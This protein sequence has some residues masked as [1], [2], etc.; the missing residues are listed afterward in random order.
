MRAEGFGRGH[1]QPREQRHQERVGA[2]GT[3]RAVV[4]AG[5]V[6]EGPRRHPEGSPVEVAAER[7]GEDA[8]EPE[9][10]RRPEPAPELDGGGLVPHRHEVPTVGAR[11][12]EV[13]HH[14]LLRCVVGHLRGQR[15]EERFG[16]SRL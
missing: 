6:A 15:R 7:T 8:G 4:R 16:A 5:L 10:H 11:R 13:D 12:V 14:Q 9:D 3:F 1:P 2:V